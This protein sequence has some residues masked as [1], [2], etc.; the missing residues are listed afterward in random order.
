MNWGRGQREDE[1]ADG[2]FIARL[3]GK[4][5][6]TPGLFDGHFHRRL[7]GL[8][9]DNV[10]AGRDRVTGLH[11]DADDRCGVDPLTEGGQTKFHESRY[12]SSVLAKI[13]RRS[14]APACS[15]QFPSPESLF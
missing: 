2:D 12:L 8:D 13:P 5:R 4:T 11:Q 15:G 9:G 7:V 10:L 14:T 1:A 6:N 3:H